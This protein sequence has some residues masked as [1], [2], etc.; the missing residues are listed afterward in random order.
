MGQ[1]AG[2]ASNTPSPGPAAMRVTWR[3]QGAPRLRGAINR[4]HYRAA[5]DLA[6]RRFQEVLLILTTLPL[7]AVVGDPDPLAAGLQPLGGGRVGFIALAVAVETGVLMLVYLNHAWDDLVASGKPDQAACTRAVIHGAALRPPQDD[8]GGDH[9]RWPV[10]HH[11]EP[12]HRLRGDAA[13][14]RPMIGGMV[15]RL[16]S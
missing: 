16:R 9:Y 11:V 4:R 13:H 15:A 1:A 2:A 7:A 6:F 12:R 14:R 5:V 10:A 3:G 8:D